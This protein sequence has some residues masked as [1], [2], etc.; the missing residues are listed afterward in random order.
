MVN[1]LLDISSWLGSASDNYAQY[2]DPVLEDLFNKMNREGNPVKQRQ[3][4]RQFERRA[5]SDM[6]HQSIVLWWYKIHPHRSY[7]KGWKTAPSHYLNQHLDQVW[8]DK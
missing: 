5:L 7:V 2:E 1:P 6:A 8:L 3:Y 4:M